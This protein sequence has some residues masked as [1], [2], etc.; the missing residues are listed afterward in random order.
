MDSMKVLEKVYQDYLAFKG[1]DI[2]DFLIPQDEKLRIMG[3]EINES[4]GLGE[5]FYAEHPDIL[6]R[7]VL[8][9]L[10][11]AANE[12]GLRGFDMIRRIRDLQKLFHIALGIDQDREE[13]DAPV[14]IAVVPNITT[15]PEEPNG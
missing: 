8:G 9:Q 2:R 5:D 6:A 14:H 3:I 13:V 4:T 11:D 12:N 10:R 7:Y 1:E 15:L